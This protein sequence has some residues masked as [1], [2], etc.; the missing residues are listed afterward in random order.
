MG[1]QEELE[2]AGYRI[3]SSA[4]RSDIMILNTCTVTER[5]DRRSLKIIR[6]IARQ[7]PETLIIVAGCGA[8]KNHGAF[9]KISRVRAIIGNREK[10]RITE[11]VRRVLQGGSRII[12]ISDLAQAPFER[13]SIDRFR[14]YTRAFVKIQEGCDR[15]C[16]Y[17]I[18]PTV[19][20]PSRSQKPD[21][22]VRDIQ[23]LAD[24]HYQ[25]IVLTGIDLGVYGL[26]L[27]PATTLVSL[28][29]A[30][31][32]IPGV[33]RIRLSS[34]EPMEFGLPLIEKLTASH[35]ICRH[36]HIPLQSANNRILKLMSRTYNREDY[37]MIIKTLKSISPDACIGADVITGF[38]GETNS[39]FEDGYRFIEL[40][41][42]D[43]LHVFSYS[44]RPGR[45]A[46]RFPDKLSHETIKARC[47]ALRDLSYRKSVN[48]RKRMIG[49]AV[50]VIVLGVTDK[51]TGLPQG[52]SDN[53]IRILLHG[54]QLKKGEIRSVIPDRVD[55][56]TCHGRVSDQ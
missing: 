54:R 35:K 2:N 53:Y 41:P 11:Y 25:E 19:R 28:L 6:K 56:L 36:F 47:H 13:L 12:D 32:T 37:A 52:L 43:Y 27:K 49:K 22:V 9:L 33:A 1:M 17:C 55:G 50:S 10:N 29:S 39:E 20:G 21:L 46:A 51:E 8:Q 45:P 44:D 26:D 34:I 3:V 30:V 7:Q 48:F 31:E 23:N 14:N 24:H 15:N 18:I 38:P 5:T 16:T 4:E 42:L 40:L